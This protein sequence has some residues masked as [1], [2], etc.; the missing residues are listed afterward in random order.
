MKNALTV[1]GIKKAAPGKLFD[2]G[3][4]T[5]VKNDDGGKWVYRYSHLGKRREMGLGSWPELSLAEARR[6]RDQWATELAADR[7][8]ISVRNAQRDDQKRKRERDDPTL[9]AA[10]NLVFEAKRA[11]LR[12]DGE[13][14]R[15]LS[16]LQNHIIPK[17]GNN[18][19]STLT[20]GDIKDAMSPIWRT[21]PPTARKVFFRLRLVLQECKLMGFDCD[22]AAAD[23]AQ[24][25]LGTVRHT[26]T[27]MPSVSWQDAPGLY[28][29]LPDTVSGELLRFLMLTGMRMMAARKA[30]F[31]EITDNIWTVPADRM[32]GTEAN[33]ADFRVALSAEALAVIDR[34]RPYSSTYL[35]PGPRGAPI[36]DAAAEKV[37]RGKGFGTPHGFR[38]TFRTWAQD[39]DVSW[40]VAETILGHRIGG[41]VERAYARSDLLERRRPVMQAW[42]DYL[43]RVETCAKVIK[44]SSNR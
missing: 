33:A 31:S 16:P 35:F 11:S 6:L 39:H 19:I 1:I 3:G 14:G 7:D 17:I 28:A 44:L 9:A 15:W 30:E 27:P 43:S 8:P 37:L 20:K 2:G 24:R 23:A 21:K 29:A 13:R 26:E 5:L 25:M 41:K 34:A 10:I 40:D 32:K 42:A 38:T 18:R 36:S 12:G 22:P 4:L